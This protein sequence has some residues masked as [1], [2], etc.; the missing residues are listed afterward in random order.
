M[1]HL[2]NIHDNS[3]ILPHILSNLRKYFISHGENDQALF[4]E[5]GRLTEGHNLV[6]LAIIP[7][8]LEQTVR[9]AIHNLKHDYG[10]T[11]V[12]D[13]TPTRN[14]IRK[15]RGELIENGNRL[16]IFIED[17][18]L[19]GIERKTYVTTCSECIDL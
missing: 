7:P 16:T 11:S 4:Y 2:D 6:T 12:L 3:V 19:F 17:H 1:T 9:G 13:G 14:G 15:R 5:N 8:E 18:I 10:L